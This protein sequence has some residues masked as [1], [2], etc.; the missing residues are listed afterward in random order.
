[1]TNRV[2]AADEALSWGIVSRVVADADLMSEANKL[3]ANFAA[4]PT[5]AYGGSKRLLMSAFQAT[6]ETQLED[7]TVSI[8]N[9]TRTTDG[10]HGID[11]F[12]N[13]S[14]PSFAG[15]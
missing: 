4:G 5:L 6:L 1:M 14:K 11:A 8:A 10:R 2:L 9:M 3:A 12:A 13:R 7:E 15:R